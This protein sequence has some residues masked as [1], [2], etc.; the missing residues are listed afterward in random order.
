M[1]EKRGVSSIISYVLMIGIVVVLSVSVYAFLKTYIPKDVAEC[2]PDVSFLVR[3]AVVNTTTNSFDVKIL[4]NGLFNVSGF[5]I[6][7]SKDLNRVSTID[8]S[9]SPNGM[10]F[11]SSSEL[12]KANLFGVGDE[13]IFSFD[14]SG[15]DSPESFAKVEIVP[16]MFTSIKDSEELKLAVCKNS[17]KVS[18]LE[19]IPFNLGKYSCVDSDVNANF[20][21]G[22]NYYT[23]GNTIGMDG[24]SEFSHED[25]CADENILN[26]TICISIINAIAEYNCSIEGKICDDGRCIPP[27]LQYCGDGQLQSPQE[28]CDIGNSC[29]ILFYQGMN[30]VGKCTD[31]LCSYCLN[32]LKEKDETCDITVPNAN[33]LC[34][35]NNNYTTDRCQNICTC[36]NTGT[37]YC[38][39]GKFNG[40]DNGGISWTEQC[41]DIISDGLS[42]PGDYWCND[43]NASTTDKC[44]NCMC[45]HYPYVGY[46]GD[47]IIQSGENCNNCPQDVGVCCG[48]QICDTNFGEDCS[49]CCLD[50]MGKGVCGTEFLDAEVCGDGVSDL[51]IANYTLTGRAYSYTRGNEWFLNYLGDSP[52]CGPMT[53]GIYNGE[54]QTIPTGNAIANG[55]PLNNLYGYIA[56]DG[57]KYKSFVSPSIYQ[58]NSE[59]FYASS[60]NVPLKEINSVIR[61]SSNRDVDNDAGAGFGLDIL[62]THT[63]RFNDVLPAGPGYYQTRLC[64]YEKESCCALSF[65][66]SPPYNGRDW[67]ITD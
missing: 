47:G 10:F 53:N 34:N 15:I 48:N 52:N 12:D 59:T 1:F 45:K 39:D 57:V 43:R 23:K 20:L 36:I 4:N 3:E 64:V 28:K 67:K 32:G 54:G 17:K 56:L 26:E 44:E 66:N 50:C 30:L 61:G 60:K 38:G 51:K 49:N 37:G 6:R 63:M 33:N 27:N 7:A 65:I 24:E 8:L 46:C 58:P 2:S 16:I 41:E 22:K 35:D 31:C 25:I 11:I 62:G 13:Q 40:G 55:Y 19:A 42:Y 9:G 18:E 21:D 5:L 29:P 14:L